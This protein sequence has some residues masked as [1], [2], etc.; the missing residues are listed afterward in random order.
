MTPKEGSL[1][2][3]HTWSR[4]S[5]LR[6]TLHIHSIIGIPDMVQVGQKQ[7]A[8]LGHS[9]GCTHSADGRA[10]C[11]ADGPRTAW[12]RRTRTACGADGRAQRGA[13][14]DAQGAAQTDA[15]G[16]DSHD[17]SGRAGD[18]WGRLGAGDGRRDADG[19]DGRGHSWGRAGRRAE[20]AEVHRD[21]LG[22]PGSAGIL[23]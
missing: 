12:R 17:G 3:D 18:G 4:Q 15:Q 13:S 9:G 10:R 5:N 7:P 19:W 20:T 6:Q 23:R 22:S 11:G 8:R 2:T 1:A 16:R 21:P 14:W